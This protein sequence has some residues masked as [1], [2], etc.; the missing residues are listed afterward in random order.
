MKT[1]WRA[2]ALGVFALVLHTAGAGSLPLVDRDEPRFAEAS[3]EMRERGDWIVPHFNNEPRL[4]KPPLVYWC[5]AASYALFGETDFAARFPSAL[6]AALTALL[7]FGF[8]RRLYDERAGLWAAVVFSTSLH[9]LAL[10]KA[11]TADMAMIFFFTLA[12]WSG[13]EL[14]GGGEPRKN[15]LS[16]RWW[17]LFYISLALGFL[18]KG[19]VAWIPLAALP[20]FARISKTANLRQAM[21]FE[22]GIPLMLFLIGLWAVPA[23]IGTNGDYFRTGI[24]KNVIERSIQAMEGHGGRSLL[25]YVLM[26]PFYFLTIFPSFWPW[27]LFLPGLLRCLKDRAAR[28]PREIYLLTQIVC[29]FLVFTLIATKLPHYTLPAF[30][31]LAILVA[32]FF[33]RTGRPVKV[34]GALAGGAAVTALAAALLGFPLAARIFPAAELARESAAWLKS[35][36][37]F[38]SVGYNEPSLV[39]VFRRSVHGWHHALSAGE[40]PAFMEKP[41][42]RFCVVPRDRVDQIFAQTPPEWKTARADGFDF[43]KGRRVELILLVKTA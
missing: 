15:A 3:R 40:A 32:A 39:W 36:M 25:I 5:Q 16:S 9:I 35:E 22:L 43:A 30:A 24:G 28:T 26:L 23:L 31:P 8:G 20:L 33:P 6:A 2:F 37:E 10:G 17:W 42:P 27:S 11:A 38:A 21:R 18:A 34:L 29:V 13:W 7:V 1:P 41:G 12:A 19:P 14:A 4:A